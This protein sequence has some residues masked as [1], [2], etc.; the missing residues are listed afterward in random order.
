MHSNLGGHMSAKLTPEQYD[1]FRSAGFGQRDYTNYGVDMNDRSSDHYKSTLKEALERNSMGVHDRW[2]AN[3]GGVQ[4]DSIQKRDL[5]SLWRKPD[6]SIDK[7][8][9]SHEGG[10]AGGYLPH[11]SA[12]RLDAAIKATAD[13]AMSKPNVSKTPAPKVTVPAVSHPHVAAETLTS[14]AQKTED[15]KEDWRQ[16]N[17]WLYRIEYNTRPIQQNQTQTVSI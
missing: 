1:T 7:W 17:E 14:N 12:A 9:K 6:S 3:H 8:N 5:S 4:P 11:P 10:E 13:A 15:N 2:V 16:A